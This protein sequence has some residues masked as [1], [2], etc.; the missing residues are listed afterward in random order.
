MIRGE[1]VPVEMCS[2]VVEQKTRSI[3]VKL[4]SPVGPWIGW[5]GVSVETC[6]SAVDCSCGVQWWCRIIIVQ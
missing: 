1:G 6:S 2:S 5:R 4:D 3:K